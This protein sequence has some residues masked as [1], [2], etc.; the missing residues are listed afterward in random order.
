MSGTATADQLAESASAL[1]AS[2]LG[3]PAQ[4]VQGYLIYGEQYTETDMAYPGMMILYT[5]M[6]GD[7]FPEGSNTG[8]DWYRRYNTGDSGLGV[9]TY[10]TYVPWRTLYMFVK[11]ANDIISSLS[12]LDDMTD[13]QKGYLG[14]AY[15]TRAWAYWQLAG[16]YTPVENEYTDISGVAG[17]TVPIVTE[18]TS[19]EDGKN[20]PRVTEAAMKEF[21]LSDLEKAETLMDGFTPSISTLPDLACVYGMYARVYLWFKDYANAAVYARKAIDESGCKPLTQEQWEDPTTG[22]C[23]ATS[24]DSWMWHVAYS[25]ETM[26]NLCNF[27]GWMAGESDWGYNSLNHFSLNRWIYDRIGNDDFRKHSFI[28]PART[29][30]YNYKFA[31]DYASRYDLYDLNSDGTPVIPNYCSYKFRC[32]SGNWTDYAVGGACDIPVMR[33]EEM[34]LIEAEAIG[35]DKGE[36][37]GIEALTNFMVTYRNPSYAYKVGDTVDGIIP[38]KTFQEEVLFQKRV[39]LWGEGPAFFDAKRIKAGSYQWYAGSNAKGETFHVNANGIKPWWTLMIPN[40]EVSN[41]V[42][43][44]GFN[45]PDP[46]AAVDPDK[47]TF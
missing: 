14:V 9:G 34:Y 44:D 17:L 5:E 30:F 22:F 21:I 45:N 40:S 8:Y 39:E 35:M 43:L 28:D 20:N 47:T 29:D 6:L 25:S 23:S 46:T 27:T 18:E 31:S 26:G 36:S 13:T 41:N 11:S 16:L 1:E 32:L 19:G 15:T 7:I 38:V 24:Q 2:V 4:Q 12:G 3:M 10:L 33:V 42:A 37:A